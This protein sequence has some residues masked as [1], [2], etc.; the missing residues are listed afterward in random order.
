MRVLKNEDYKLIERL[1]SLSQKDLHKTMQVYLKSKYSNVIT[2]RILFSQKDIDN[3][4]M[5]ELKPIELSPVI[6]NK[7]KIKGG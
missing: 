2:R 4:G 3:E 1:V 5:L 7:F 6:I